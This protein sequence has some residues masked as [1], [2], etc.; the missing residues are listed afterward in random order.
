MT[1]PTQNTLILCDIGGTHARIG[2]AE[3]ENNFAQINNVAKYKTTDF[4]DL[5]ATLNQYLETQNINADQITALY[6]ASAVRPINSIIQFDTSYK[7]TAWRIEPQTLTNDFKITPDNVHF[8]LDT[9]AQ[10]LA[11]ESPYIKDNE[12]TKIKKGTAEEHEQQKLLISIGTGL[13]HAY[14]NVSSGHFTPTYGGHMPPTANT[15]QQVKAIEFIKKNT[16]K[17]QLIFEDI[18]SG[19]GFYNLYTFICHEAGSAPAAANPQELAQNLKAQK[20]TEITKE[21]ARLFSEFLGLYI[22]LTALY[23]HS[24]KSCDIIG[25]IA[26]TLNEEN[27]LCKKSIAQNIELDMVKVVKNSLHNMPV[28]L[29]TKPHL[30]LYGLLHSFKENKK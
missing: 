14:G 3:Q 5:T 23:T 24:Y 15:S 26:R 16:G 17:T 4:K 1:H 28:N 10:F 11:L 13:G 2:Y 18:I 30:S 12:A 6:L 27:L 25:G 7:N 8:L 20:N 29:I 22:H 9:Q 21:T 19:N